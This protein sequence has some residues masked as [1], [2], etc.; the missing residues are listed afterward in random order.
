MKYLFEAGNTNQFNVGIGE[1]YSV[2]EIIR[3]A[4][5]IS[6]MKVP[7]EDAPRRPGDPASLVA[8]SSRIQKELGWKAKNDLN[9][10]INTA[11]MWFKKH[12]NGF[13][14]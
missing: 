3:V 1:G 8:D 14:N 9:S 10:I 7:Y 11:W 12:P 13:E 6:G 4:E 5:K 2:R